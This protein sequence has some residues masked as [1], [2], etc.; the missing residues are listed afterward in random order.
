MDATALH[1]KRYVSNL[2]CA[3]CG[4]SDIVYRGVPR[5]VLF[6]ILFVRT[7]MKG[8]SACAAALIILC[9]IQREDGGLLWG[10]DAAELC[11]V[12]KDVFLSE[13]SG[14]DDF[15][16]IISVASA[17]CSLKGIRLDDSPAM[18]DFT[19]GAFN[20][21]PG[22][23]GLG[24][25]GSTFSSGLKAGET[26][27]MCPPTSTSGCDTLRVESYPWGRPCNGTRPACRLKKY[28]PGHRNEECIDDTTTCNGTIIPTQSPTTRIPTMAPITKSPTA[29]LKCENHPGG[30]HSGNPRK[31]SN[32]IDDGMGYPCDG[33]CGSRSSCENSEDCRIDCSKTCATFGIVAPWC[34]EDKKS[35]TP[36]PSALAP[37]PGDNVC[38]DSPKAYTCISCGSVAQCRN[39]MSCEEL[40]AGT[41]KA[42]GH[43]F[44]KCR[45]KTE[46]P[47]IAT[48]ATSA[49]TSELPSDGI[50]VRR[51]ASE[52]ELVSA[53]AEVNASA[54]AVVEITASISLSNPI[55]IEPGKIVELRGANATVELSLQQPKSL[56]PPVS[57]II[58]NLGELVIKQLRFV[59]G[60]SFSMGGGAIRNGAV[61]GTAG[62]LSIFDSIFE[63]NVDA[64]EVGGG[65]IINLAGEVSVISGCVFRG[66]RVEAGRSAKGG[67][68][69][70]VLYPTST[71][72]VNT[73]FEQNMV[74]VG[75]GGAI[76]ITQGAVVTI[77]NVTFSNNVLG[78][79]TSGVDSCSRIASDNIFV[80]AEST[81][82][83]SSARWE[84]FTGKEYLS[85]TT[86]PFGLFQEQ[87]LR[88][89][90]MQAWVFW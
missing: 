23:V 21:T 90:W 43:V 48:N 47:T 36:S 29:P 63:S 70:R 22:T 57:S 56:Q 30:A 2:C 72:I 67:G 16:E 40:C 58:V 64:S 89:F 31:G 68:A 33:F 17:P 44:P 53:I 55:T 65:A 13:T 74:P 11:Q 62:K 81:L 73:L 28:T 24:R 38:Q 87:G 88:C 85:S 32:G 69:I 50:T 5:D 71:F 59:G 42:V 75:Q 77:A 46:A 78:S 52:M 80:D 18:A 10:A 83:I 27:Y 35:P 66:N 37:A 79:S 3:R 61:Q 14:S 8:W 1:L 76:R 7:T 45:D 60:Y 86:H 41:C 12:G 25:R 6:V 39:S 82:R 51:V 4:K 34:E 15:I 20:I 19:I 49:P 54:A 9:A 84:C 26:V